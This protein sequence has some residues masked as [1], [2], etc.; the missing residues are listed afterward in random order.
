MNRQAQLVRLWLPKHGSLVGSNNPDLLSDSCIKMGQHRSLFYKP[1]ETSVNP[2][3]HL[4]GKITLRV[5]RPVSIDITFEPFLPAFLVA[6]VVKAKMG[7]AH[8][9]VTSTA[10][11]HGTPFTA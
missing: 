1:P 7:L 5:L 9:I 2:G 11:T 10:T 4:V 6:T 8:G 3:G